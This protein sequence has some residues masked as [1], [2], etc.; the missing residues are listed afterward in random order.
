MNYMSELMKDKR[1]YGVVSVGE[2]GQ[3]VI[4]KEARDQFGIKNG[5]KLVVMG[6]HGR[7]LVLLKAD[8]LKKFAESILKQV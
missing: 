5:D 1:I 3:I 8:I 2:R 4:P 6:G 7:A